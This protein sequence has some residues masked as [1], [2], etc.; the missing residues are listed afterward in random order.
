MGKYGFDVVF[1][2]MLVGTL[3][4]PE[5][6]QGLLTEGLGFRRLPSGQGLYRIFKR[7]LYR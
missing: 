6:I 5:H 7:L 3:G 1:P 2:K 4:I